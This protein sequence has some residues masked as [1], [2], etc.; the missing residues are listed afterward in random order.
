MQHFPCGQTTRQGGPCES[1]VW[2]CKRCN[3]T[4]VRR[5]WGW[6]YA[7][8]YEW[9]CDACAN[10]WGPHWVKEDRITPMQ[11]QQLRDFVCVHCL[12]PWMKAPPPPPG[13]AP[14]LD[15]AS[16]Q[17]IWS[18]RATLA[19]NDLIQGIPSIQTPPPLQTPPDAAASQN[20]TSV[21][22]DGCSQTRAGRRDQATS[23]QS[24]G[25]GQ[26]LTAATPR[27]TLGRVNIE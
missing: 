7:P 21:Q 23:V 4:W 20:L 15:H 24:L 14:P 1:A 12:P 26:P 19:A 9:A 10:N 22:S 6:A 2:T 8:S 27:D 17:S 25:F 16:E 11:R 3:E 13:P 5:A 18:A